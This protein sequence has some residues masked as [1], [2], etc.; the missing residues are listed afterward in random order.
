MARTDTHIDTF[1]QTQT[2]AEDLPRNSYKHLQLDSRTQAQ[3][4]YGLLKRYEMSGEDGERE[5][6][7]EW[8]LSLNN[9]QTRN[10]NDNLTRFGYG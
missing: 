1:T 10:K 4:I 8:I 2:E 9:G 7:T 6:K 5:R 3:Q